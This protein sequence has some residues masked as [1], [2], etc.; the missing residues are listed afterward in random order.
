VGEA[1][2]IKV[3]TCEADPKP[4]EQVAESK[5]SILREQVA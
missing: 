3:E 2:A 4:D 1:L 5:T